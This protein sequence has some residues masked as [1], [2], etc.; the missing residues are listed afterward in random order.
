MLLDKCQGFHLFEEQT[1]MSWK[2]LNYDGLWENKKILGWKS[3]LLLL[4]IDSLISIG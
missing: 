2:Y 3:M 1:P 4:K